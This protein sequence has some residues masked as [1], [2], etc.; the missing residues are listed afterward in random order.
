MIHDDGDFAAAARAAIDRAVEGVVA[1]LLELGRAKL[2]DLFGAG[3]AA[4]AVEAHPPRRSGPASVRS[5]RRAS[6]TPNGAARSERAPTRSPSRPVRPRA[7]TPAD[8]RPAPDPRDQDAKPQTR[9]RRS[10]SSPTCRACGEPGHNARTCARRAAVSV[11]AM[12][13]PAPAREDIARTLP[14][15]RALR[16]AELMPAPTSRP[17]PRSC[18]KC[19]AGD[20]GR[21]W[22]G[23][24]LC[25][26]CVRGP[27]LAR[28]ARE[29]GED[30]DQ[31]A[32]DRDEL[33]DAAPAPV[34]GELPTPTA[35]FTMG[36]R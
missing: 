26:P 27:L 3:A 35:S 28:R 24:D 20:D 13:P 18:R 32:D 11:P 10:P 2:D 12:S 7:P 15:P 31:D 30:D 33:G 34:R 36:G 16:P 5:R 6:S 25:A 9:A 23:L 29:V 21:A 1:E 8:S 4:R 22:C 14:P 19:G 17:V